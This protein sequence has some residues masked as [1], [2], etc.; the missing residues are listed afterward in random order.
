MPCGEMDVFADELLIGSLL[1][2]GP[3]QLI[4]SLP[5]T[6]PLSPSLSQSFLSITLPFW[7]VLGQP[8]LLVLF[9][10]LCTLRVFN[11]EPVV[12]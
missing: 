4:F 3:P 8:F 10:P 6:N 7:P 12:F 5:L 2:H 1:N 9:R 11:A